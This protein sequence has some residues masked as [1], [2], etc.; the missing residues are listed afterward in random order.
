MPSPKNQC[1]ESAFCGFDP[2]RTYKP[3]SSG[4]M[5]PTTGR[6]KSSRSSNTGAKFPCSHQGVLGSTVSGGGGV[7]DGVGDGDA[8]GVAVADP[9]VPSLPQP[10]SSDGSARP[11]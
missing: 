8:V 2:L 6:S 7:G 10:G 11:S 4:G 3:L 5:A 1:G 9:D